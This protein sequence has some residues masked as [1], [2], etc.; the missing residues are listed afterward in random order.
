MSDF[1]SGQIAGERLAFASQPKIGISRRTVS[2]GKLA[3]TKHGKTHNGKS[4]SG[5]KEIVE[6]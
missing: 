6:P 4:V 1:E 5:K 2:K 3:C